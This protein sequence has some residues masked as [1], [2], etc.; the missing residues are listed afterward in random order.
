MK[1]RTEHLIEERLARREGGRVIFARNL[2]G[3]LRQREL[4]A[5]GEKLSHEMNM[6]YQQS[7]AGEYVAGTY[8]QR[9][10]LASGRFAMVD[11]GLGFSLVPWT[12]S[13]EKHIGQH[14]SGVA[15]VDGGI[16]WS[17]GRK[18]GLGL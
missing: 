17:F 6:T 18:R 1:A 2:L 5:L 16:D 3:T 10:T 7:A 11:D 14:I 9:F 8:R 4:E 12:P 13:V 15:R